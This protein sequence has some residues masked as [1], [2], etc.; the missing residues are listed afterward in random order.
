M[1]CDRVKD[2]FVSSVSFVSKR[3]C[4]VE[5]EKN[6]DRFVINIVEFDRQWRQQQQQWIQQQRELVGER[7]KKN[8]QPVVEQPEW[9]TV[10]PNKSNKKYAF[11]KCAMCDA[12]IRQAHSSGYKGYSVCPGPGCEYMEQKEYLDWR[13]VGTMGDWYWLKE[14]ERKLILQ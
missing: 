7:K 3:L 5:K 14:E 8:D 11:F 13:F 2:V 6:D 4:P 10:Q 1:N 9:R 12:I